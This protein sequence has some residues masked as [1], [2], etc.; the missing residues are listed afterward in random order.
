MSV[1]FAALLYADLPGVY[2]DKDTAGELRRFLE[3]AA[4]PLAELHA[5]VGQL[6][7]DLFVGGCRAELI[8]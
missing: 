1:D 4:E 3:I 7:E 8:L 6:Y 2:R 5:S